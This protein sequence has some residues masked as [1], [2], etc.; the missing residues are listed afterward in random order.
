MHHSWNK[1]KETKIKETRTFSNSCIQTDKIT[2]WAIKN[3]ILSYSWSQ[4]IDVAI[5]AIKSQPNPQKLQFES[6]LQSN[7]SLSFISNLKVE[8]WSSTN[9]SLSH[10]SIRI[11]T[12]ATVESTR[13]LSN[14]K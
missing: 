8:T 7:Q 1:L 14:N 13:N 4:T 3:Y 11:L 12:L 5:V 6:Q 9:R 2:A 10:S